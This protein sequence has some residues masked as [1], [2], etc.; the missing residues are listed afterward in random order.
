M[1][2][3]FFPRLACVMTAAGLLASAATINA[4][5]RPA[6]SEDGPLFDFEEFVVNYHPTDFA[7]AFRVENPTFAFYDTPELERGD[8]ILALEFMD[9]YRDSVIPGDYKWSG[10]LHFPIIDGEERKYLKWMCLY[11][12][13]GRMFAYDPMGEY[14]SEKRFFVPISYEDRMNKDVL[15]QFATSYV[16]SVFPEREEDIYLYEEDIGLE[17]EEYSFTETMETIY[18][19]AG[20]IAPVLSSQKKKKPEELV[21]LIYRYEV[22][23]NPGKD[24]E[25]AF[26]E[27]EDF[28]TTK[29]DYGSVWD[30]LTGYRNNIEIARQLL[31]PRWSQKVYFHYTKDL[32]ILPDMEAKASALVFNIG[33]RIYVYSPKY[34]VWRTSATIDDLADRQN[35]ASKLQYPGIKEIDRVEFVSPKE[36]EAKGK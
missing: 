28:G 18:I 29:F 5:T 13:N 17:D 21:R 2:R 12:Y 3:M 30:E 35:F 16:E 6:N 19:P 22:D 33:T 8:L 9:R 26:G 24:T 20:R 11:F 34:G 31:A 1:K 7:P 4:Q 27:G 23:P 10:M 36:T 32:W 14:K 15:F 25:V